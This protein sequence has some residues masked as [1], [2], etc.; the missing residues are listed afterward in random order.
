MSTP[1]FFFS[2]FISR[3]ALPR[4]R[5]ITSLK[6]LSQYA[7]SHFIAVFNDFF[8]LFV[9]VFKIALNFDFYLSPA[10]PTPKLNK[11]AEKPAF[12]SIKHYNKFPQHTKIFFGG[13]SIPQV[14]VRHYIRS[15]RGWGGQKNKG[16]AARRIVYLRFPYLLSSEPRR[17]SPRTWAAKKLAA[18]IARRRPPPGTF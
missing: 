12:R 13:N 1:Y 18:K 15:H 11:N 17:S 6:Y 16:A 14:R 8:T 9:K 5:H 7:F 4:A 3:H 10:I 2:H